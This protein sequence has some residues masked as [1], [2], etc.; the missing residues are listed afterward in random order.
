[1]SDL[2]I[3][4]SDNSLMTPRSFTP[5][6]YA[7]ST[8]QPNAFTLY[9]TL[10]PFITNLKPEIRSPHLPS[11]VASCMNPPKLAYTTPKPAL[12]PSQP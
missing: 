1:M 5:N 11:S 7:P 8:I 6:A 2:R 4:I 3:I 12:R 9:S 10:P